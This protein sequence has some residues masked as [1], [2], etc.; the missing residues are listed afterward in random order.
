MKN[1]LLVLTGGTIGSVNNNG[2]IGT[3]KT[4]CRILEMTEKYLSDFHF[5]VKQPLNILSE[6]IDVRHWEKLLNFIYSQDISEYDGIIIT[7]GS[8]TLSY[9]SAMLGIMLNGLKIPV[10]ITAADKVPGLGRRCHMGSHHR[11]VTVYCRKG[12]EAE[13]GKRSYHLQGDKSLYGGQAP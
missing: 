3:Q 8:D 9:S 5:D 6:N 1:I 2:I 13:K 4:G 12:G 7:H 11:G 10:A